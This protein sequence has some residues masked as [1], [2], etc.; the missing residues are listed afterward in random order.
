[1][2]QSKA[3]QFRILQLLKLLQTS[4]ESNETLRGSD[5]LRRL[6]RQGIYTTR[7]TLRSDIALLC[8]CG[9]EVSESPSA[10]GTAYSMPQP[11][12]PV[13]EDAYELLDEVRIAVGKKRKILVTHS[14]GSCPYTVSPYAIVSKGGELC[15][16]GFSEEHG[17]IVCLP[18]D[19]VSS[20]SI[21]TAEALPPPAGYSSSYYL[22][23]GFRLYDAR[24]NRR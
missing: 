17:R 18:L 9:F 22:S 21:S 13:N 1:M 2:T 7:S 24:A 10:P 16:V 4:S 20:V 14:G 12:A 11:D 23:R 6:E 5:I 8:E 15:V 3:A 19:G